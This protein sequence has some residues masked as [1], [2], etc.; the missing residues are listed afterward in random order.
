LALYREANQHEH[1]HEL[2]ITMTETK[3]CVQRVHVTF[4]VFPSVIMKSAAFW[5]IKTQSIP[6]RR[7]ITSQAQS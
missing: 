2:A 1:E 5:D 4:E 6:H 3:R 7:H